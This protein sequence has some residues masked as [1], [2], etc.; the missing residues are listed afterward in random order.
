MDQRAC[1]VLILMF[2]F[3]LLIVHERGRAFC[4]GTL[5]ESWPDSSGAALG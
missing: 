5:V 1:V 2:L 4:L 3:C